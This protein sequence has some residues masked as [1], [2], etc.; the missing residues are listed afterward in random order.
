MKMT[1]VYVSLN[2]KARW[3]CF[4]L[5]LIAGLNL[6][7]L[8]VSQVISRGYGRR[9]H[10]R[11]KTNGRKGNKMVH[12]KSSQASRIVNITVALIV[13]SLSTLVQAQSAAADAK[14]KIAAAIKESIAKNQAALKEYT[15]TENT[16]ISLKGEVKK[17]EEN[18]CQY[19]PD[20][21]VQKTPI[22]N[23]ANSE[24]AQQS[25]GGRRGEVKK[26][27]IEKKVDELKDY[28]EQV[29]ALVKEYVPPD[30]KKI[31]AAQAAGNVSM[32][33][34]T[35]DGIAAMNIKNY[36][37][38][39]DLVKLGFDTSAKKLRSFDVNSY[40]DNPQ[41][42]PV[43]LTVTFASLPDGT[44]YVQ[45]SVLDAPAKKIQVTTT[46]SDYKKLGQ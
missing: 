24:S 10:S 29:Q 9:Q 7:L 27:M 26:A 28:M 44:N 41:N 42:D 23:P 39:G 36:V 3:V 18:Q 30:P 4:N 37:K 15:W 33:P 14:E 8:T 32:Q 25:S 17:Q 21:K 6:S 43:T 19:G 16:Q 45:Q 5:T 11:S 40:T 38:Q 12:T 31:Q 35:A 46:S 1:V 2:Q 13:I 34:A 20:G 22:G